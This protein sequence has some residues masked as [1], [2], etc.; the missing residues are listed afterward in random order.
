MGKF[1]GLAALVLAGTAFCFGQSLPQ[2]QNPGSSPIIYDSQGNIISSY[3]YNTINNF[4]V[5]GQPFNISHIRD[6]A[7]EVRLYDL[8]MQ[9]KIFRR[10]SLKEPFDQEKMARVWTEQG[11]KNRFATFIGIQL[12]AS[13]SRDTLEE[14]DISRLVMKINGKEVSPYCSNSNISGG[15]E[16]P[17]FWRAVFSVFDQNSK[18]VLTT[19]AQNPREF[20][21][22][23]LLK[24]GELGS[25]G[26]GLENYEIGDG[27]DIG[28]I[29]DETGKH[30][31]TIPISDTYKQ[32]VRI[33][34][35]D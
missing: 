5:L 13:S 19:S 4:C 2:E 32:R 17:R 35:G 6:I 15:T 7:V 27:D 11:Y 14:L 10:D 18:V 22:P 21:V 3:N 1:A 31:N 25:F 8:L 30:I 34:F 24:I 28:V 9:D 33:S 20:Y 16:G 29:Y 12:G 23:F 26:E